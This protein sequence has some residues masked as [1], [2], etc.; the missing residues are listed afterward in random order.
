MMGFSKDFRA[1][2]LSAIE[3]GRRIGQIAGNLNECNA[4]ARCHS[5]VTDCPKPSDQSEDDNRTD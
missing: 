3:A 5:G 4:I 2:Q 1:S